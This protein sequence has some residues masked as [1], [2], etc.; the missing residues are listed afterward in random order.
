[1]IT[2]VVAVLELFPGFVSG[3]LLE[4]E[5]VLLI[6]APSAVAA[7]TLATIVIEAEAP[8]ASDLKDT[9]RLLPE[10]PQVPPAV[11]VQEVKRTSGGR[12]SVTTTE[13]ASMGPLLVTLMLY[14]TSVPAITG[15]GESL[16]VMARSVAPL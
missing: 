7:L 12:L 11:E 5:A 3:V 6:V 1:M 13:V 16:L 14:V 8:E 9:V 10:P 4:T 2:D 15:S